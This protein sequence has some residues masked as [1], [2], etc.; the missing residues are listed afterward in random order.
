M[1]KVEQ[2]LKEE[3]ESIKTDL[4]NLYDQ[5]GMRASGQFAD[6]LEVVIQPNLAIIFGLE[7]AQ[8][9]ELG[10]RAGKQ[11]PVDV[12]EKWIFD[13]QIQIDNDISSRS[14]AFLIARKIGREGWDRKD[15]GG[16][17][18]ISE[19]ITEQRMQGI[20]DKVGEF[21]VLEV[22]TDLILQIQEIAKA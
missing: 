13:K 22:T 8:Q 15:Q 21:K 3:F 7:Y 17:N 2:I 19:V 1:A 6:S 4:I 10:R 12:I 20:I 16:V 14:L 11:P 18:L 5:K 9:L